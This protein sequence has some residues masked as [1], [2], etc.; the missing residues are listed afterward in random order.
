[1]ITLKHANSQDIDQ[2]RQLAE[3]AWKT[4]YAA[5]LSPEQINYML[6]EMYS[7]EALKNDFDNPNYQYYFINHKEAAIG[8]MGFELNYEPQ[9]T[10]LHRIYLLEEARGKSAGKT[11]ISFLKTKVKA[12]GNKRIILNV[13]KNNSAINFYENLGFKV[14]DQGVFDIGQGFVMDDF[15]MEIN[16]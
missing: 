15:L 9:T 6:H 1:M 14:Y 3:K 10:K 16:L 12:F 5:I 8:F 11:A 2:V 13:N 7:V 4:A